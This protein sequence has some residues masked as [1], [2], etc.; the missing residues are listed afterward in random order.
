MVCVGFNLMKI[1]SLV[2]LW[3]WFLF[4]WQ[5][6]KLVATLVWIQGFNLFL[7]KPLWHSVFNNFMNMSKWSLCMFSHLEFFVMTTRET[8]SLYIM[9]GIINY[10]YWSYRKK[11]T[12]SALFQKYCWLLLPIVL[13]N[14]LFEFIFSY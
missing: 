11:W 4:S 1:F 2:A 5:N 14:K 6:S 9:L 10:S 12:F 13:C 8:F 7:L 3:D